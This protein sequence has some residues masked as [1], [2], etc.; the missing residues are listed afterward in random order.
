MER[1]AWWATVHRVAKS[2]TRLSDCTHTHAEYRQM[3]EMNC[4]QG[5]NTDEDAANGRV[6]TAEGEQQDESGGGVAVCAL[7]CVRQIASGDPAQTTGR[8][9][10]CSLRGV[11]CGGGRLYREGI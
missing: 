6:G 3:A 7:P 11:G 5:R 4:L 2:Q 1:G 10:Q 9:P 8:S